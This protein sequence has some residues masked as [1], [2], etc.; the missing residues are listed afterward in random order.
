MNSFKRPPRDKFAIDL[1]SGCGGLTE[2]LKQAGFKVMAALE[3]D[4]KASYT[5]Q[6]NHPEVRVYQDNILEVDP[7]V[8][9]QD[10][11][12]ARGELDLLAG[13]PP[14][15]GF[16]RLRTKNKSTFVD[17]ERNDLIHRF[18]DYILCFEP[19]NIM[20]E[21]VPSLAKDTRFE[22]FCEKIKA[23]GYKI[24][25]RIVDASQY[26]VPQ[27]RK[28]LIFLASK[29]R[30]PKIAKAHDRLVTVKDAIGYLPKPSLS[31][32]LVHS[33]PENRSKDVMDII[34]MIPKDGGSR[35]ELPEEYQLAC[36]RRSGG[37]RDVYGRMSWDNI[38][39]TIT[40]GC[41]NP[42]KGR[43][44]HPH[45]DRTITLREASL[46]QGFPRNYKFEV[47]HGKESIALMIGNALPPP[48]IKAQALQLL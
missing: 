27:R 18:Y 9:R 31:S 34:R 10:F 8:I 28:R 47:K 39:P 43:F 35:H 11:K 26:S 16:S 30:K 14:C 20:M 6:L 41:S 46:L 25:Y 2:G 1:F 17:D 45:D 40:S 44:I 24:E 37:F 48:L 12:M 38:S 32:D 21:N 42:S 33:Y 15:Q 3:I 29:T 22:N 7:N 13:C 5:Y 36:A 23:L 4:V 19:K